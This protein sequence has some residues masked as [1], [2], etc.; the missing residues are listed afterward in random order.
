MSEQA[1]QDTVLFA[2][3]RMEPYELVGYEKVRVGRN[4][5]GGYVMIDDFDGIEAAY[6]IGINDDVSWDDDIADR[7][8]PVFQ[9]DHTITAPP[10]PRPEFHWQ[11][12]GLAA[13]DEVSSSL[14]SLRT[15]IE[16]NKHSKSKDLILKIDIEDAEWDV[17]SL[18]ET[19]TLRSFRQIVAEFHNL[20]T[21][22][23]FG[24][25][26]KIIRALSNLAIDHRPV[27]VHANNNGEW[28]ILGSIP[29][30]TVLEITFVRRDV[31]KHF[32][33]NSDPLPGRFDMPNRVDRP[34]MPL[35]LFRY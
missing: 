31:D 5:D 23:E 10:S 34:D 30:P 28:V 15:E 6:S 35:G 17:F 9:Y 24:R 21:L 1:L 33:A 2:L 13:H 25:S 12:L 8:I 32:V 22:N 19:Q 11:K 26:T 3:R 7:G 29:V 27:H 18:M 14:T 16:K 4:N 20:Q